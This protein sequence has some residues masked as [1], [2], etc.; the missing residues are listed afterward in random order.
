M[1]GAEWDRLSPQQQAAEWARWRQAQGAP[2]QWP[3][4]QPPQWAPQPAPYAP[5][6]PAQRGKALAITSLVLGL[7]AAVMTLLFTRAGAGMTWLVLPALAGI[8]CGGIGWRSSAMAKV[9]LFAGIATILS[10][11]FL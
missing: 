6:A 4:Q 3:V 8:V 1:M 2:Q 9:G 5:P 10:Q 11:L 7:F